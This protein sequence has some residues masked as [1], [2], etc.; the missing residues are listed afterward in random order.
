MMK[1]LKLSIY[2]KF[3][4]FLLFSLLFISINSAE[5]IEIK[6]TLN[7]DYKYA[8]FSSEAT[9]LNHFFKYTVTNIPSSRVGAF[10]IDFNNFNQL[11]LQNLV[12]CT[13]VDDSATDTELEEK[14]RQTTAEDTTCVG[15]FNQNGKFDGIIEYDTT[16]KKLGIYLVA[17]G[18]IS[19]QA[20]VYIR[21]TEKFLSVGEQQVKI[22][23]L[24]SLIPFTVVISDF[25]DSA[26]RILFYS[27]TRELQMY[28]VEESTPYPEK[29]FSGNVM[30]VYTNPNMVHQ[31]YHDANYMVLLTR[32]FSQQEIVSELFKYEVKLRTDQNDIVSKSL[33]KI[34]LKE[35]NE[36]N[37]EKNKNKKNLKI[38]IKEWDSTTIPKSQSLFNTL[39]PP[40]AAVY[41]PLYV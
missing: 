39:L 7:S 9:T 31:K 11:S 26:S 29:L 40:S 8:S 2:N 27:Y 16:K 12:F 30:S 28:Y 23:E 1:A 34:K 36:E 25:R 32:D 41:H 35:N 20:S 5:I 3:V 38:N 37:N 4:I 33:D 22:E 21:T 6:N 19:F 15:S 17:K 14:L 24:Y 13:F 10:R 18:A